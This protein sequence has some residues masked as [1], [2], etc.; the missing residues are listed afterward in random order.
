MRIWCLIAALATAVTTAAYADEQTETT[1]ESGAWAA[2]EHSPSETAAPDLC[3]AF[4]ADSDVALRSDGLTTTFR[5]INKSW[6]LPDSITGSIELT[7]GTD[8]R[9]LE[10]T[11]NDSNM[12]EVTLEDADLPKLLDEMAKASSMDVKVGKDNPLAVSLAGS[13][14]VLNSFRTCAGIGG[15]AGGGGSNPF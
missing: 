15:T 2:V 5:V 4:N 14:I 12:V 9:S 6:S 13:T 11:A 10:I 3:V 1:A 8:T 7:I